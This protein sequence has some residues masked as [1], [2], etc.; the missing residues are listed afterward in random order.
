MSMTIGISMMPFFLF[1]ACLFASSSGNSGGGGQP[2]Q[3]GGWPQPPNSPPPPVVPSP[4]STMGMLSSDVEVNNMEHITRYWGSTVRPDALVVHSGSSGAFLPGQQGLFPQQQAVSRPCY[5][6]TF[7]EQQAI[8]LLKHYIMNSGTQSQWLRTV[9]DSEIVRFLRAR[10]A[11][12]AA[13]WIALWEHSIWRMNPL[14]GGADTISPMDNQNFEFSSLNQEMYW[15]GT[16]IHSSMNILP[17]NAYSVN[18]TS[19][20][21]PSSY[22][23]QL[24]SLL[25]HSPT[26]SPGLAADGNPVLVFRSA[27]HQ[28]NVDVGFFTRF[29]VWQLEKGKRLYG[30]GLQRQLYLVMDRS[31][32][33]TAAPMLGKYPNLTKHNPN[34]LLHSRNHN[35][36]L[37]FDKHPPHPH[38]PLL[39]TLEHTCASTIQLP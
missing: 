33:K 22:T 31:P 13:T 9:S 4:Q 17:M 11:D 16:M 6:P 37:T 15:A 20:T 14:N 1:L 18:N 23:P 29:V 26:V 24:L 32:S 39:L 10:K 36:S 34:L 2:P 7:A 25:S 21:N 12:V 5:E 38:S 28:S 35:L 30:V 3:F 19:F 27:L 8:G